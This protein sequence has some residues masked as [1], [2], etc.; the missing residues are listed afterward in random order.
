MRD[1][2]EDEDRTEEN[3]AGPSAPA[4]SAPRPSPMG[5]AITSQISCRRGEEERRGEDEG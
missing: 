1:E 2:D 4:G 3:R 5:A